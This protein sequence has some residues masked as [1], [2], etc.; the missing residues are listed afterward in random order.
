MTKQECMSNVR[1]F[2]RAD[3]RSVIAWCSAVTKPHGNSLK[4]VSIV[5]SSNGRVGETRHEATRYSSI[6]PLLTAHPSLHEAVDA[7]LA[8][9]AGSIE[10]A[11][12][13]LRE[14][15]DKHEQLIG[16]AS[17]VLR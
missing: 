2:A 3:Y 5:S 17:S 16:A 7:M 6:V 14:S 4:I 13:A 12:A 8:D 1:W 15:R 10:D 11:E 9:S